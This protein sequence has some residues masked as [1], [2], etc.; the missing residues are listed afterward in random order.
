MNKSKY[1]FLIIA[2]CIIYIIF[3]ISNININS[4]AY[5][6]KT[7]DT[8]VSKQIITYT[9]K[10]VTSVRNVS[11]YNIN[12]YT[13]LSIMN[14]VTVD[15][16]NKIINYWNY[17]SDEYCPFVNN[18]QMFIDAS[19]ETGLDPVYILAHAGLESGWG[20][21]YYARN[22]HNYFG[23]GAFDQN[24]DNAIK[25]SNDKMEDGIIK[26]AIWIKENYYENGQTNLYSMRYNNG[27]HEYCTSDTWVDLIVDIMQT[28][29]SLIL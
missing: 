21:S 15:D 19:R 22:Y 23:I 26:G 11:Y 1:N 9:N 24:P 6:E 5:E 16:M 25:Y 3:I 12:Y 8:Q 27:Y 4:Y 2:L 20:T 17:Y 10:E 13:D 18:G 7:V 29:Y 14:D 28:S